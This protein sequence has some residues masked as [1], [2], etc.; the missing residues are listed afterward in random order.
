MNTRGQISIFIIG[1]IIILFLLSI[2]LLSAKNFHFIS[3]RDDSD[4]LTFYVDNCIEST[5]AKAVKYAEG[6]GGYIDV[7]PESI[8][9]KN[10]FTG[11]DSDIAYY[12]FFGKNLVP[13]LNAEP[14]RDSISRHISKYVDDELDFCINDFYQVKKSIGHDIT[15]GAPVA[16]TLISDNKVIVNVRYPVAMDSTRLE[17][18]HVEVPSSLGKLYGYSSSL[19]ENLEAPG[20]LQSSYPAPADADLYV[21]PIDSTRIVYAFKDKAHDSM[22]LFAVA[23]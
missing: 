3:P 16:E 19:I 23:K 5:A 9:L 22:L 17:N 1:G 10:G 14:G 13:A 7:P 4:A 12:H 2:L 18:F 21:M 20:N 15:H 6:T 8:H 11:V